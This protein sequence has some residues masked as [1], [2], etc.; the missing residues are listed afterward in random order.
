VSVT[1][2]FLQDRWECSGVGVDAEDLAVSTETAHVE[3]T[4]IETTDIE[5][6][7]IET[8]GRVPATKEG[9]E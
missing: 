7:D 5:T 1:S 8:E 9:S 2:S 6:A 4:V 3:S